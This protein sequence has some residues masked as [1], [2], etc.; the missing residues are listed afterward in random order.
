MLRWTDKE[1][2]PALR[3]P[4]GKSQENAPRTTHKL[5][6]AATPLAGRSRT[7]APLT[8]KSA[9]VG[10][11]QPSSKYETPLL[12]H[13]SG[14]K[15]SSRSQRL[16]S[17]LDHRSTVEDK[18]S[19]AEPEAEP[20]D[21]E[22]MAPRDTRKLL[23]VS[24][25]LTCVALHDNPE[26]IVGR[27]NFNPLIGSVPELDSAGMQAH[28]AEQDRLFLDLHGE[29]TVV[30]FLDDDAG[31]SNASKRVGP[32]GPIRAYTGRTPLATRP[33]R[34]LDRLTRPTESSLRKSVVRAH[35]RGTPA[36]EVRDDADDIRLDINL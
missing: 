22:Y 4:F 11:R 27:H 20:Q 19:T 34:L 1:N 25:L 10:Q 23:S 21:I 24:C 16:R 6:P 8:A 32:T 28:V 2:A 29:D 30:P 36:P 12:S 13:D 14:G 18:L 31:E 17:S 15:L 3:T 7:A 26:P 9:N 33:T 35:T 5:A